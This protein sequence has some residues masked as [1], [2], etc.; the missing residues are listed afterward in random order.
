MK[1][2]VRFRPVWF[3]VLKSLLVTKEPNIIT[4][5]MFGRPF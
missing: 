5:V 3:R 4:N 2:G 1:E